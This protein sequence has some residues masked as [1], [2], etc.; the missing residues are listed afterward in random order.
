MKSGKLRFIYL[1]GICTM[2]YFIF[3]SNSGGITGK[4]ASGCGGAGCHTQSASTTIT[5]L[6]IPSP[7]VHGTAYTCTLAVSNMSKAKG[8]FD[9]EV[10]VGTLSVIAGQGTQLSGTDEIL[11]NTPKTAISGVSAWTFTWTAPASGNTDLIVNVAGNA[12]D[13]N[14]ASSNDAFNTDQFTFTAPAAGL[15]PP[16]IT[17]VVST[18]INQVS[19]TVNA[20][21]NANNK[22]TTAVIEYGLT[23]AYGSTQPMLPASIT[24]GTPTAA[25]GTIGSLTP[26]TLY[27]YR[28][29]ATNADGITTST[30]ATFTTQTPASVSSIEKMGIEVYPNPVIDYL[31]YSNK[32]NQGN[33]DFS[34]ISVNGVKQKVNIEKIANGNYKVQTAA[35]ASGNYVLLME[36]N[37]KKYYHHFSK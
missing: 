1:L 35:L 24:G 3:S 2:A 5:L 9:L 20:D 4:A 19:A 10:N 13:G 30:D 25:T 21:V 31:I 12:V 27:H 6:G 26:N 32:E 8:G 23:A 11:H 14:N 37:G 15:T 16:T 17:N 28:V 18:N 34:I 29:K 33:V 22:N 7:Y 36:L